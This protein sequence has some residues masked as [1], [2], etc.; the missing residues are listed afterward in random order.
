LSWPVT[1]MTSQI[2]LVRGNMIFGPIAL[3]R[4]GPFWIVPL[5]LPRKFFGLS[6]SRHTPMG[7]AAPALAAA[8]G[9]LLA[10]Q[11]TR[12]TARPISLPRSL[13]W[14]LA[15]FRRPRMPCRDLKCPL[16]GARS[17]AARLRGLPSQTA[18]QT[19][20]PGGDCPP[21]TPLISVASRPASTHRPPSFI[22][23]FLLSFHPS[24][25]HC[26]HPFA[27]AAPTHS[28]QLSAEM[29]QGALNPQ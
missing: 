8:A 18:K 27:N 23:S 2:S 19:P 25:P 14:Y 16:S 12:R 1:S 6:H 13:L 5:F 9:V 7:R 11:V 10:S 15:A 20:S 26:V 28:V 24:L 4:C 29:R 22:S 3:T 21:E 17:V